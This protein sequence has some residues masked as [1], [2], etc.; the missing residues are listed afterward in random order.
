MP[1]V[2]VVSNHADATADYLCARMCDAGVDHVRLNTESAATTCSVFATQERVI[3]EFESTTLG[4]S[5]VGTIWYRRPKPIACDRGG[6]RSERM[7]ATAEWTAALEGF[8]SQVPLR[9]WINHPARIVGASS[10][11]EQLA[12]AK[13]L[14]LRVPPWCCTTAPEHAR[15]FVSE[16]GHR[17]VAKPLYCG[18]IERDS[19]G[20][21]TVIYTSRVQMDELPANESSLGAP[22]LFQQEVLDGVDVRVT[23]VDGEAIAVRMWRDDAEVDIRRDNMAGVNYARERIP[24][25]VRRALHRFVE[26]Y[27]L[28]FA[29]IDMMVTRD[30]WQFLELNPNGQWAWL[31]LV[32]DAEIY[33]A[34]LAAFDGAA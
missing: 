24:D 6:D 17:V 22:T 33:R 5:E 15:A 26:S 18:Y 31:D 8:L 21:D 3:L 10:K 29:A 12:R 23:V 16:H 20:A 13:G 9:R 27:E 28:R 11:L 19:P 30:G 7:F 1:R 34:F 25:D 32:G 14:G 2:L 4:P